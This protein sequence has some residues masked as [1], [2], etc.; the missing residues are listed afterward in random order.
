M[1]LF[2]LFFIVVVVVGGVSYFMGQQRIRDIATFAAAHSLTVLGSDWDIDD[3]GFALFRAGNRRY[4]RNVLRG[5]WN[6]LVLQRHRDARY[7]D[8]SGH[9]LT[10]QRDRGPRGEV[11]RRPGDP[12]RVDR[13]QRPVRC[14][15]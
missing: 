5:Q 15:I 4:W 7:A 12:V 11:D 9:C 3:R 10:T 6:G 8:P 13:L 2:V 1:V 14:A